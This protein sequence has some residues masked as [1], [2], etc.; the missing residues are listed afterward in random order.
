[1]HSWTQ[2]DTVGHSWTQLDTVG[3]S[4]TQ[5]STFGCRWTQLDIVG[6]QLDPVGQFWKQFNTFG[7]SWGQQTL[8][9]ADGHSL[10]QTDTVWYKFWIFWVKWNCLVPKSLYDRSAL[11]LSLDLGINWIDSPDWLL[12]ALIPLKISKNG[13]PIIWTSSKGSKSPTIWRS[14]IPL[15]FKILDL[16]WLHNT[17]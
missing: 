14:G 3:H 16:I 1:M 9:D 5:L 8:L 17:L 10:T 4:W 11:W 7:H 6:T 12:A 13:L 2:L 15:F